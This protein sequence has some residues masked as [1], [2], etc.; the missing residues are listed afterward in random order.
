MCRKELE[1]R[2]KADLRDRGG[3]DRIHP[4]PHSGA[5]VPDGLDTRL[6]VLPPDYLCSREPGND[7]ETAAAALLE[8]RGSAPRLYR[9]TL[10][11][12]AADR[13][14][15]QDLDE[16]LRQYL[17]WASILKD[18]E[19][20]N[21]DP[22]QTRQAE[23]RLQA[24]DDTVTARLPEAYQWLLAPDQATPRSALAWQS[25]RLAGAG[26]GGG[27]GAGAGRRAA[28]RRGGSGAGVGAAAL[29]ERAGRRLLHD[30]LLVTFLGGAILRTHLD[31]V[32]LW[33]GE[34][35]AVRQ[36]VEDF[37]HYPYLPRLA[38]PEGLARAVS[39][40]LALL[41]WEGETFALAE[42]HD[43]AAG[44]YR[45]LQ[46]GGRTVGVPPESTALLVKP[47]AARRQ[48]DAEAPVTAPPASPELGA[49]LDRPPGSDAGEGVGTVAKGAG[50]DPGSVTG[51][52]ERAGAGGAD[53]SPAPTTPAPPA[54]KARRFH[55][56]VTLDAIRVGRDAGRIAEEVV[57]HLSGLVGAE[58]TVTLEIEAEVPGGAP[59]NVVRTVTENS[60][61]LKFG[62]HGF[63]E[64]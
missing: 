5:D 8:S 56:A 37:A 16:A 6:A 45:G 14:R 48:W 20:L 4:L 26:A 47:D 12:L 10:V 63:E 33:R 30:E 60:R 41:I 32:P 23:T 11:F 34:H 53:L 58:V 7:A 29:A 1:E 28:S 2:L 54:K 18:K 27:G 62:S 31:G 17:A 50:A 43:E 9:N 19:E 35:V 13:V 3:F 59:D 64:S 57:A 24:V 22:H 44:R 25:I 55:D 40:G 15:Y 46:P 49:G 38:G 39:D 42:G 52:G 36:L 51:E 21:L 61:T